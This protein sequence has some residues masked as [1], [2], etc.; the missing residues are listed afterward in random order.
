[1]SSHDPVFAQANR[2]GDGSRHSPHRAVVPNLSNIESAAPATTCEADLRDK[3]AVEP[4]FPG[5]E[6]IGRAAG[7]ADR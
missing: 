2:N 4:A 7:L 5:A 6:A 1:M 3:R